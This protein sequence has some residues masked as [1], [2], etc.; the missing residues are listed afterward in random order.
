MALTE[1]WK[2]NR[3]ELELKLVQQVIGFAGE[4][5]LNDGGQASKEFR[6]FL[7]LVPSAL[8]AAY[9]ENCL[10]EK[11]DGSGFALQDVIN[12]VG[13]RLGFK[14]DQGRYRGKPQEIG[15]DGL[16]HAPDGNSIVVE[17]KTTD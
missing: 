9:A 13:F 8:L 6:E 16:W 7:A 1:F 17:V 3:K 15:Y 10:K 5:K 12:Q 11:I 2:T 14:V 4:G